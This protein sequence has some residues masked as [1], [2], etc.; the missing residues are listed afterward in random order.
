MFSFIIINYNTAPLTIACLESIIKYCP[1]EEF[2]II[3]VDNNSAISDLALFKDHFGGNIRIIANDKNLGFTRA[4]NQGATFARGDYL[5]F[6]NSDTI[7]SQN[8]L[9]SLKENLRADERIGIIAPRLIL[10]DGKEQLYSYGL[11]KK[12]GEI[13]W[14]S[15]AALVIRKKIFEK[16]G[17]WDEKFFMYFEDVDLCRRAINGGYKIVKNS[18]IEIIHLVGGSPI[19]YYRRKFFYYR[20]KILFILKYYLK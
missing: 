4:N 18:E 3:L 13:I 15:G 16:I 7:I 14:V 19:P 2:E 17:G 20:S 12:T 1:P 11:D 6:L 5:F 8:I 9:T 10:K